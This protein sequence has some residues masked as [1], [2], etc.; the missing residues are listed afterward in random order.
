MQRFAERLLDRREHQR[1]AVRELTGKAAGACHELRRRHG[2][3]DD[4]PVF[5]LRGIDAAAGEQ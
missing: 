2:L 5:R 1:R 4:A 3:V